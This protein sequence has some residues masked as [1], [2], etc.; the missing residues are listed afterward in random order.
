MLLTNCRLRARGK[1]AP[2]KK[3]GPPGKIRH[4]PGCHDVRTNM[5][6]FR[7]HQGQE[8]IR[9]QG[10]YN[11]VVPVTYI[12]SNEEYK[13]YPIQTQEP[14]SVTKCCAFCADQYHGRTTYLGRAGM[15]G[16]G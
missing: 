11:V 13:L 16:S 4:C 12:L 7:Y 6:S 8:E 1:G 5:T 2:K 3:K 14:S 15:S 10:G 9:R